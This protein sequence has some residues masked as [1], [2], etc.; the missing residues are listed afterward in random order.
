MLSLVPDSVTICCPC[1]SNLALFEGTRWQYYSWYE[2]DFPVSFYCRRSL[3]V[4]NCSC[5]FSTFGGGGSSIHQI[6][7]IWGRWAINSSNL[8]IL[9]E[10]GHQLPSSLTFPLPHYLS[11]KVK[12]LL[13]SSHGAGNR[14]QILLRGSLVFQY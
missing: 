7:L 12:L 4:Y 9:G 2:C 14:L 1:H 6:K 3:T 11:P 13:H 10:V 8:A 5:I